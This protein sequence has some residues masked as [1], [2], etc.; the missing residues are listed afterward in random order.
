[1]KVFRIKHDPDYR[2]L[3]INRRRFRTDAEF[4][5]FKSKRFQFKGQPIKEWTP[6]AMEVRYPKFPAPD[7]WTLDIRSGA[8]GATSHAVGYVEPFLLQAGQLLPLPIKGQVLT[9]CHILECQHCIDED[10]SEWHLDPIDGRRLN[11]E[12]PF[13]VADEIPESTLFK[14]PEKPFDICTW[15]E[16]QDPEGE[17]KACVEANKLTGLQF[18]PM[19]SE[20]EGIIPYKPSWV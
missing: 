20:D 8:F 13:F 15:E 18:E 16:N 6:P 1:M 19:W 10:K 17:F 3:L 5:D 7:F 12:R 2:Y 9:I 4:V 14:I 11:P